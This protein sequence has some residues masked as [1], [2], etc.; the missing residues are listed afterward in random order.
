MSACGSRLLYLYA[1]CNVT[2]FIFDSGDICLLQNCVF[3]ILNDDN[4]ADFGL[5]MAAYLQAGTPA[6]GLQ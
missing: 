3:A 4:D 6:T 2:Q 1:R 5:A